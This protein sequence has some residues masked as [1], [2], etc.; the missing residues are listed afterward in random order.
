MFTK[1]NI[2]S[3]VSDHIATLR[4][5]RNGKVYW[6]DIVLFFVLPLLI[7]ILLLSLG[8]LLTNE[9]TN[10]IV[11]SLSLFAGLLFNLLVLVYEIL[12]RKSFTPRQK[13]ALREI[14]VNI[15]F[16]ILV[17]LT[18]IVLSLLHFIEIHKCTVNLCLLG[19]CAP[20]AV[21]IC[22]PDWFISLIVYYLFINFVLT[23]FM[24]LKRIYKLMSEEFSQV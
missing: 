13:T 12:S 2:L 3:I 9:I 20:Q 11:T 4:N 6:P 24:I 22:I 17:S 18:T 21:Y 10:A 23:L 14:Y 1:I 16:G 15:S 5:D 8:V 19:K 7:S